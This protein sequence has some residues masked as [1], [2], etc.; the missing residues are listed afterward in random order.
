[1]VCEIHFQ[2]PTHRRDIDTGINV[3][4]ETFHRTRL[5]LV[6]IPCPHCD[7][8]HRFLLADAH[9]DQPLQT[10]SLRH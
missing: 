5:N 7:R 10:L 2:C 9:T 3:D 1:M 8:M 6:H 4:D